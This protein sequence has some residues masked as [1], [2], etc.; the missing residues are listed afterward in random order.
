MKNT[1]KYAVHQIQQNIATTLATGILILPFFFFATKTSAAPLSI[2]TAPT[3][4]YLELQPGQ[5][6]NGEIVIWN[7]SDST[8]KYEIL[9]RG[10]RQI[11]NQPGTAIILTEEE[12]EKALYSAS[13]WINMDRE[14]ILL[15]PNRNEKIYYTVQVPEDVTKGEY[16]AIIAFSSEN[17]TSIQGT[18]TVTTLSAG[19]PI[20]IKVGDDFVEN[21]ELLKF[22]TSKNFYEFPNIQFEARIKNIGDTHISPTGEIVLTNILDQEIARI[23]VNPNSQSI[24]RENSGNYNIN[25]DFGKFLTSDNKIILGPI[26]ANLIVTYRSFQPGFAPLTATTS[27]WILPWKYILAIILIIIVLTIVIKKLVKKKPHTYTPI[28]K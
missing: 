22:S 28:P 9:K 18:A 21:A 25:W 3:S 5:K 20:L 7:L 15:E 13:T 12:N 1:I 14:N 10:F 4:E 24:L 16:N 27:F 26:T 11:E 17:N 2:G 19:M 6:Y 23:P 8:T